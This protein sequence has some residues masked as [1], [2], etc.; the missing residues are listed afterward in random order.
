MTRP[1]FLSASEPNPKRS[2]EYWDNRRLLNV[3][4]A[5]RALAFHVLSRGP[6]VFGGHPAI[7]P[8]VRAIKERIAHEAERDRA[9]HA[10]PEGKSGILLYQTCFYRRLFPEDIEAFD[11][12]VLTPA[13][14][15][16]GGET[17]PNSGDRALSL[18]YMRYDMIGYP[19]ATPIHERLA[20]YG[21]RFGRQRIERFGTHEFNAAF[22]IGGMEGVEREF[23]IFRSFHPRTPAWPIVST[24]SACE[25]ILAPLSEVLPGDVR[26]ALAHETAY[27]LLI[28]RLMEGGTDWIV[29]EAPGYT[30]LDHIDPPIAA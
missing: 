18:L 21:D 26:Q 29:R 28:E 16:D 10:R 5:V 20:P 2:P 24:G 11:D 1:I 8:L 9:A 12:V 23:R 22:F 13:I 17:Y 3:R 25:R 4:E 14:E 7:T 27:S 19:G 15:A 30:P 6:L